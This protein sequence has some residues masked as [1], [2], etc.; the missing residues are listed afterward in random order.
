MI[1]YQDV[2]G[3]VSDFYL[4]M[5]LSLKKLGIELPE[6]TRANPDPIE[7]MLDNFLIPHEKIFE[8]LPEFEWTQKYISVLLEVAQYPLVDLK[9]LTVV[10]KK[11]HAEAVRQKRHW[12]ASR[13]LGSFDVIG[14]A[15]PK[16]KALY[17]KKHTTLVDDNYTCIYHFDKAGGNTFHFTP[18]KTDALF[19]RLRSLK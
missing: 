18:D 14:V 19:S 11:H 5:D 6:P 8:T 17:A 10:G 9:F 12:L 7:T 15:E 13:G 4:G 16:D 2:D 1:L 3:C